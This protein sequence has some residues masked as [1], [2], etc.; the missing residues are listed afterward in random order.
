MEREHSNVAVDLL[1]I[2]KG[3]AGVMSALR[4]HE[5]GKNALVVHASDG[6]S[7]F[8]SGAVNVVD[9]QSSLSP[10]IHDTNPLSKNHTWQKQLERFSERH[11]SHPYAKVGSNGR[12]KMGRALNLFSESCGQLYPSV[13][14]H[15]INKVFATEM[16]TL[17][18]ALM[19]QHSQDFDWLDLAQGLH[20][21]VVEIEGYLGYDSQPV[22][23][24][25]A[26]AL[27]R[28]AQRDFK[29]EPVSMD[30]KAPSGFWRSPIQA[31][32]ALDEQEEMQNFIHS[33]GRALS[34]LQP[35]PKHLL[36]PPILGLKNH[37]QLISA[38]ESQFRIRARELLGASHAIPGLRLGRALN[39]ALAK[40]DI[41]TLQG[42]IS[43]HLKEG[44]RI[45]SVYVK[46]P[47]REVQIKAGSVVLASG[48][49]LGGGLR[50][51]SSFKDSCFGLPVFIDGRPYHDVSSAA[52]TGYTSSEAHQIFRAGLGSDSQLRPL[53]S[54]HKVYAN[55]LYAAGNVLGGFD[56]SKDGTSFGVSL[57]TGYLASEHALQN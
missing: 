8:A 10:E 7:V 48:R 32:S 11:E 35:E 30:Y 45:D 40:R 37:A 39:S 41:P 54:F 27:G 33:L 17:K 18:P 12:S 56:P 52:L 5:L 49:H 31:A 42:K 16:G 23:D 57:L 4:A 14:A 24:M 19:A 44:D 20:I 51:K 21:G 9:E 34:R 29:F 13:E 2:G 43:G 28:E 15:S 3:I 53:D 6:A 25:L 55:N 1:V 50:L 22:I 46:T 26:W 36:F 38:I 47:E